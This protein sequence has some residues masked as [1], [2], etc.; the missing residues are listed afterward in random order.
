MY[1]NPNKIIKITNH[2]ITFLKNSAS[3]TATDVKNVVINNPDEY[4]YKNINLF[5]EI[6]T[7]V[8]SLKDRT[9]LRSESNNLA[10][11]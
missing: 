9:Y 11:K 5:F 4:K 1:I 6:Y 8:S 3:P 10:I 2:K 7:T